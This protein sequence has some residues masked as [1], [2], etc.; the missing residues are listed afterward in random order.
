MYTLICEQPQWGENV[1]RKE[2][3]ELKLFSIA[4]LPLS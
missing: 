1:M 3:Q 4:D 2:K